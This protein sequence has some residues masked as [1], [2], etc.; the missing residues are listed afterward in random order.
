MA[1]A[2]EPARA[3]FAAP[4]PIGRWGLGYAQSGEI[5]L[6]RNPRLHPDGVDLYGVIEDLRSDCL[7]AHAAAPD[8]LVGNANTQPFRYR[9]WMFA[10]DG[11]I[12][13]PDPL[14]AQLDA[15][16]PDFLRRH[17]KGRTVAEHA[18]HV[19]L[20]QLH[21]AGSVD[22]PNL[23]PLEARRLLAQ[24]V[25]L[26][27]AAVARA[28][29]ATRLGNLIVSNGRLLVAAHLDQA[30]YMRRLTVADPRGSRDE[31]FRGVLVVSAATVPGAG[32][33]EIPAGAVL[34]VNRTI[35]TEIVPLDE[36]DPA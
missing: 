9:Q 18:F 22:A 13:D 19:F 31:S 32:F 2:L 1:H 24:A 33:E 27:R 34:L 16:I 21:Q 23:A 17:V 30:L 29:A 25:A 20:A 4:G 5:L 6:S 15:H 12:D 28:D 3:A 36:H 14:C 8:G 35:D 11:E 10:Q 26:I 7:I